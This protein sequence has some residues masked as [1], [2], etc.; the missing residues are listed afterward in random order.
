VGT[1]GPFSTAIRRATENLS[2]TS[3]GLLTPV[4]EVPLAVQVIL[5]A[6]SISGAACHSAATGQRSDIH[7]QS[8]PTA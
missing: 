2:A 8:S 1:A 6:A 3:Y 7:R 4:H 5:Q